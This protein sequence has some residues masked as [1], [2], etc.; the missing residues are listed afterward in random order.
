MVSQ[1]RGKGEQMTQ[2]LPCPFC[3]QRAGVLKAAGVHQAC[4]ANFDCPAN[5]T[6]ETHEEAVEVWN[7]RFPAQGPLGPC[8]QVELDAF[9][10]LDSKSKQ[11]FLGWV[12]RALKAESDA[13][14]QGQPEADRLRKG[15]QDYLDGN[16]EHPRKNRGL[17]PQLR[18]PHGMFYWDDCGNCIDEHFSRLLGETYTFPSTGRCSPATEGG[19]K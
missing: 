10:G 11:L 15:I 16:Y 19:G 7:T 18:C 12:D 8:T 14:A 5:G 2:L 3:G 4:C 17:D 9:E 6:Y 1:S 13:G